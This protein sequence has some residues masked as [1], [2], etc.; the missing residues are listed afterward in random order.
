MANPFI[1]C[2]IAIELSDVMF[3]FDSVPAVIAVT[4]D[5]VMIYSAMIFAILGL[6]SLYFV[7]GAM[8]RYLSR[9]GGA[10]VAVLFFIGVKLGAAS[11]AELAEKYGYHTPGY[12][13]VSPM[14][15]LAIVLGILAIGV[16][17]SI[18]WPEAKTQDA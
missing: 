15:S 16:I 17:A 12:I 13:T 5:P 7:L 11:I 8:L 18:L 14:V 2:L 6:R 10:V 4:R 9:L 1:P 3:S